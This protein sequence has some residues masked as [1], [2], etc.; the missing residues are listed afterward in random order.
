MSTRPTTRKTPASVPAVV[1]KEEEEEVP[2]VRIKM[3]EDDPTPL[4][5]YEVAVFSEKIHQLLGQG[6][7]STLVKAL[8][9][10]NVLTFTCLIHFD[11]LEELHFVHQGKQVY[12]VLGL[13]MKLST[14]RDWVID[15]KAR[16]GRGR[17]R[18]EDYQALDREEFLDYMEDSKI[19]KVNASFS[20]KSHAK[21]DEYERSKLVENFKK[22]IK[23]DPSVFPKLRDNA[24]FQSFDQQFRIQAAAQD[25][26]EITDPN[27]T[28]LNP[29]EE[30]LFTEKQKYAFSILSNVIMTDKGKDFVREFLSSMDAQG[31]YDKIRTDATQS[32]A[33]RLSATDLQ[34]A[35]YT[36]RLDSNYRGTTVGFLIYW[37]TCMSRLHDIL[38]SEEHFC[39]GLKKRMLKYAVHP[40]FRL[41]PMLTPWNKMTLRVGSGYMALD[42][43]SYIRRGRWSEMVVQFCPVFPNKYVLFFGQPMT[44][45]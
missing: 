33:A 27:Y 12:P 15:L 36:M 23:R 22:S 1:K 2:T 8:Q 29:E 42:Y 35:L 41:W 11:R 25:I 17:L 30:A 38:P 3:E 37:K 28:P 10:M 20:S 45:F 26:E 18:I 4:D 9:A 43:D 39:D 40:H 16:Y 19:R 44:S 24:H 13:V 32:T 21:S 14:L 6:D 31:L 5:P 34:N 7:D